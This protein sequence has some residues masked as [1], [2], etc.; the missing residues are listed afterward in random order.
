L[1]IAGRHDVARVQQLPTAL[2]EEGLPSS[3]AVDV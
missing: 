2:E 3:H 1:I